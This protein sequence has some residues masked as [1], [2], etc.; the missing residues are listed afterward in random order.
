M[1]VF[2]HLHLQAELV[3]T[4]AYAEGKEPKITIKG[5]PMHLVL[6]QRS[7]LSKNLKS[8]ILA[9][10]ASGTGTLSLNAL[11]RDTNLF[12]QKITSSL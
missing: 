3:S 9:Q 1:W 4:V 10:F 11:I 5:K 8:L 7:N 2:G 12:G 6:I